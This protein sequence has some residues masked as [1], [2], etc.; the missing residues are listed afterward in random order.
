[1]GRN[2]SSLSISS[3]L[4]LEQNMDAPRHDEA[5]AGAGARAGAEPTNVDQYR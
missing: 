5:G 3:V 1:M 4:S 2:Q